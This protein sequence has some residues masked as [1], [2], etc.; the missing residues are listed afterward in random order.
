VTQAVQPTPDNYPQHGPVTRFSQLP[1]DVDPPDK[2]LL[3]VTAYVRPGETAHV[4]MPQL[5]QAGVE[6][7]HTPQS[8]TE[9]DPK[10][11]I[12]PASFRPP[13]KGH[14]DHGQPYGAGEI[15]PT[16]PSSR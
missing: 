7:G 10:K 8:G 16:S 9:L 13:G 3:P 14:W 2:P 15:Y 5:A 12:P 4:A 6:K 11:V 1:P